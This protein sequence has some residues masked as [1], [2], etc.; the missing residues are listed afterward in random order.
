MTLIVAVPGLRAF[1]VMDL[2]FC[3][4]IMMPWPVTD[5]IYVAPIPA[6]GTDA[7]CPVDWVQTCEGVV[8]VVFADAM[9]CTVW[10]LLSDCGGESLSVTV[11]VTV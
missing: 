4:P 3:P 7:V 8:I 9:T 6:S 1:Q 10:D 2:V 5:Q 11:S